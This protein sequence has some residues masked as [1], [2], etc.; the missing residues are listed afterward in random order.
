MGNDDEN[1]L[2]WIELNDT[3]EQGNKYVHQSAVKML[4]NGYGFWYNIITKETVRIKTS[5]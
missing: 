3:E 1:N 5:N 4:Q 2:L